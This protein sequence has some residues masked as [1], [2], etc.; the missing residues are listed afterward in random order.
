MKRNPKKMKNSKMNIPY[1]SN[2]AINFSA[3]LGKSAKRTFEPSNGGMGTR[4][5]TPRTMLI[6]IMILMKNK[7]G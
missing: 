7:N 1:C 3:L 4:L 2:V 6:K 5:K